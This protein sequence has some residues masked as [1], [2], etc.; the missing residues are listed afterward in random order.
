M[1]PSVS[2]TN[3]VPAID[4]FTVTRYIKKKTHL[5]A[6]FH[7]VEPGLIRIAGQLA[8]RCDA[9]VFVCI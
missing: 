8:T 4:G 1:L 5:S 9:S 7:V 3:V 6:K 2:V